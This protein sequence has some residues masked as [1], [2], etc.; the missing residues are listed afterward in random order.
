MSF[1]IFLFLRG[2]ICFDWV[3]RLT[4]CCDLIAKRQRS[5]IGDV[6]FVCVLVVVLFC[7]FVSARLGSVSFGSVGSVQKRTWMVACIVGEVSL[8]LNLIKTRTGTSREL[9][10]AKSGR[11]LDGGRRGKG[12]G[13]YLGESRD[14]N[15]DWVWA[16]DNVSKTHWP[17]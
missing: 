16:G 5:V 6:L 1:V 7:C 12:R 15:G 10:F 9:F 2:L 3:T 17:T 8:E 4:F 14:I 11:L 13:S